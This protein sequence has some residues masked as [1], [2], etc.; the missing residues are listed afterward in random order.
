MPA[1]YTVI[2]LINEY[3]ATALSV[4]RANLK[5]F[6]FFCEVSP[7]KWVLDGSCPSK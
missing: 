3:N 2:S 7:D 4:V 1:K 5:K 6:I